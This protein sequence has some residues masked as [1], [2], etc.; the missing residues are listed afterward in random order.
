M[1]LL[2]F[3][4]DDEARLMRLLQDEADSD[5]DETSGVTKQLDEIDQDIFQQLETCFQPP[6]SSTPTVGLS[7][8]I[9]SSGNTPS[10]NYDAFGIDTLQDAVSSQRER[11]RTDSIPDGVSL[12]WEESD[13]G[14][15]DRPVSSRSHSLE[16]DLGNIKVNRSG[17]IESVS[18]VDNDDNDD[19][20]GK[21]YQWTESVPDF[22]SPLTPEAL[23]ELDGV[24]YLSHGNN[25]FDFYLGLRKISVALNDQAFTYTL[26]PDVAAD[27][28]FSL[29]EQIMLSFGSKC[30]ATLPDQKHRELLFQPTH[31][32]SSSWQEIQV[33]MGANSSKRRVLVVITKPSDITSGGL[34]SSGLGMAASWSGMSKG[35][36]AVTGSGGGIDG[37][38]T[39]VKDLEVCFT[40]SLFG[41]Q[42]TLG[43]MLRQL[44]QADSG[45]SCLGSLAER[46]NQQLPP[47][48]VK[49]PLQP[50]DSLL[51]PFFIRDLQESFLYEVNSRLDN[52][53]TTSM[54]KISDLERQCARLM[55]LLRPFYARCAITPLT[56]PAKSPEFSNFLNE[57]S[58]DV[59]L[60]GGLPSTSDSSSSLLSPT[61]TDVRIQQPTVE[62][63][64]LLI[65]RARRTFLREQREENMNGFSSPGSFNVDPQSKHCIEVHGV[66]QL[67]YSQLRDM[68]ESYAREYAVTLNTLSASR[69]EHVEK[70]RWQLVQALASR[71]VHTAEDAEVWK[72]FKEKFRVASTSDPFIVDFRATMSSMLTDTGV[73]SAGGGTISNNNRSGTVFI[74]Q[75][76]VYFSSSHIPLLGVVQKI[77]PIHLIKSFTTTD[78]TLLSN[79][80]LSVVDTGGNNTTF[81]ISSPAPNYA[82][83]VG[84]LLQLLMTRSGAYSGSSNGV[85]SHTEPASSR[86]VPQGRNDTSLHSNVGGPDQTQTSS[87]S[88]SQTSSAANSQATTSEDLL[89]MSME[90]MSQT[91]VP[92]QSRSTESTDQFEDSMEAAIAR[93]LQAS[94]SAPAAKEDPFAS[95]CSNKSSQPVTSE[96]NSSSEMSSGLVDTPEEM[97]KSSTP[98]TSN[99]NKMAM[100]IQAFLDQQRMQSSK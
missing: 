42:F 59:L 10:N 16:N 78:A 58:S 17:S 86:D 21:S 73:S 70:F 71:D 97:S 47:P 94:S 77:I 20:D 56:P 45:L 95:L 3:E 89:S 57:K 65:L 84:D 24:R 33:F 27:A 18:E 23:S 67:I 19:E 12:E 81:W 64:K 82:S 26:R 52:L 92:Q 54:K 61:P 39:L 9:P 46:Q 40:E 93:S 49:P 8:H 1:S 91:R 31:P 38:T 76:D 15:L 55:T 69:T 14:S 100:G 22:A 51:D 30:L 2:D 85:V 80:T 36:S 63:A 66:V 99:G 7:G 37:F 4:E 44:A 50:L 87:D 53:T 28:V 88:S 6:S 13:R 72:L 32:S 11:S 48:P 83:R 35:L 90:P 41:E 60:A 96:E 79:G 74:T 25:E 5:G 34:L 29:I 43:H 68:C 75:R 62:T 98:T